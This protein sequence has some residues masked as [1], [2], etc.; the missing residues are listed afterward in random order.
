[1]SPRAESGEPG[2]RESLAATPPLLPWMRWLLRF[3]GC[4]NLL[5]GLNLLLFYH[6]LF[7]TLHLAKPTPVMF[8]QLVGLLVGLF[9]AGY[10][11]VARRPLENRNLLWLGL[12]S[13]ALGCGLSFYHVARGDLPL[14]YVP[15]VI[16]SDLVY[17]P[18]FYL[19]ARRLDRL[20]AARASAQTPGS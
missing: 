1:M 2:S 5:V 4:Y 13:K 17:L 16:F 15:I 7:K 11:M 12:W 9:G 3:A 18:P 14:L 10:L 6:E 19:I 20:A 8:V